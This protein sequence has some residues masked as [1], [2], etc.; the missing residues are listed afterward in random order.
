[1]GATSTIT[2]K[3]AAAAL[4]IHDWAPRSVSDR[5]MNTRTTSR[6]SALWKR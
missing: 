6:P 1:M 4:V 5:L 2:L 3:A